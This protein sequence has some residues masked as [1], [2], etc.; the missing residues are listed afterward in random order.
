MS[1]TDKNVTTDPSD[2]PF[3]TVSDVN[4]S[5]AERYQHFFDEWVLAPLRILVGDL[6]A[7]IGLLIV[8]GFLVMGTVGV[9]V[10]RRPGIN[11]APRNLQPLQDMAYPLGTDQLGRGLL[12]QIVHA[13]PS[14]LVMIFTGGVFAIAVATGV[15]VV[16]GYKRGLIDEILM[17]ISDVMVAIPGLPLVIVLAAIFEP[18]RPSVIGILLAINVWAGLAR[19]I[20]S[21]VLTLRNETY[22]EAARLMDVSLFRIIGKEILP[23]LMPYILIKF[24]NASR[25]VIFTSVAL[26]FLGFLPSNN[27]NWGVMISEAYNS[28]SLYLGQGLHW[29]LPPMLVIIALSLGLILLAQGFDR[30]F[31]PTIRAKHTSHKSSDE[32]Y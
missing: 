3:E 21:E 13:T 1:H 4:Q 19:T 6:R 8:A 31:N 32:G 22:V 2:S 9:A 28:N 10:V 18:S 5:R 25:F 29:L 14:M 15:G 17:T 27:A 26:Y 30:I 20:R 23:N 24:V 11:Q 16:A 12:A 7:L